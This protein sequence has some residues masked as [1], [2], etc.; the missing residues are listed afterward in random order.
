VDDT[1]YLPRQDGGWDVRET[2]FEDHKSEALHRT[3][4]VFGH[5]L[6]LS[7]IPNK[8][9]STLLCASNIWLPNMVPGK[10]GAYAATVRTTP[11]PSRFAIVL[12]PK[13][14]DGVRFPA[15]P[16]PS[17]KSA[18]AS[19]IPMPSGG[20]PSSITSPNHFKNHLQNVLTLSG[21]ARLPQVE[22]VLGSGPKH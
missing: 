14:L 15:W 10:A 21:L 6:G 17:S 3:L 2:M 18:T 9:A 20:I 5:C 11:T 22:C 1:T 16:K 13:L 19:P 12:S 8:T 7:H 4:V